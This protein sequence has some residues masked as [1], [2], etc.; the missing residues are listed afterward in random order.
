MQ[1]TPNKSPI[2]HLKKHIL[3]YEKRHKL[4]TI[5][6]QTHQSKQMAWK[7]DR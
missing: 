1:E 4:A 2:K 6:D 5:A 3:K 7:N